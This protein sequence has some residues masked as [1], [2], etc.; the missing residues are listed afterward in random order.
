MSTALALTSCE[1][2][3]IAAEGGKG[4]KSASGTGKAQGTE[5]GF[6]K[7]LADCEAMVIPAQPNQTDGSI[8]NAEA[9]KQ[10]DP[11]VTQ[12]VSGIGCVFEGIEVPGYPSDVAETQGQTVDM[13]ANTIP[14]DGMPEQSMA[15]GEQA[16]STP[17]SNARMQQ[18]EAGGTISAPVK[19]QDQIL[20]TVGAYIDTAGKAGPKVPQTVSAQTAAPPQEEQ[21]PAAAK[22]AAGMATT[23]EPDAPG[24]MPGGESQET[25]AV[26]KQAVT[27]AVKTSENAAADAPKSTAA[28]KSGYAAA[29]KTGNAVKGQDENAAAN[30]T[31]DTATGKAESIGKRE[32][33]VKADASESKGKPTRPPR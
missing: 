24:G 1:A 6:K 33:A 3:S 21:S 27:D 31:Q 14:V 29:D 8:P 20:E 26:R 16:D 23:E 15:E 25:I 30:K 7:Q 2:Q 19:T 11:G 22:A 9:G 4:I 18:T 12:G 17:E 13:P 28:G 32:P 10:S 5:D